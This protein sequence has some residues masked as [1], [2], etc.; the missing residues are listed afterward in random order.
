VGGTLGVMK[1]TVYLDD[2]AGEV[3]ELLAEQEHRTVRQQATVL[4]LKALE[5]ARPEKAQAPAAA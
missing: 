3:L 1:V 4:L 5:A 2:V